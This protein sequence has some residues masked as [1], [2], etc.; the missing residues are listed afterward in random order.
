[1][2]KNTGTATAKDTVVCTEPAK[3]LTVGRLPKGATL[4]DGK[5]CWK[6]GALKA[7]ATKHL[8][9]TVRATAT[10]HGAAVRNVASVSAAG[11]AKRT[12]RPKVAVRRAKPQ[13]AARRGAGVTG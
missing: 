2:V 12:A 7:G 5:V 8:M 9:L 1:V 4:R 13:V 6:V 10:A 11:V 3:G